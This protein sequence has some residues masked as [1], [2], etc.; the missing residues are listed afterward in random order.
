MNSPQSSFGARWI[1]LLGFA[2]A[3]I[4]A[5]GQTTPQKPGAVTAP[6]TSVPGATTPGVL[7]DANA[8]VV[9][10]TEAPAQTK[11]GAPFRVRVRM[12]RAAGDAS[13]REG[14]CIVSVQ[15]REFSSR[16]IG[17]VPWTED[18]DV[19]ANSVGAVEIKA[20]PFTDLDGQNR[21]AMG[22][23]VTRKLQVVAETPFARANQQASRDG[24][25]L[26]LPDAA[27]V[28]AGTSTPDGRVLFTVLGDALHGHGLARWD[29]KTGVETAYL[30]L[31]SFSGTLPYPGA[32]LTYERFNNRLF[33]ALGRTAENE[34][35]Q[36]VLLELDATTL[37]VRRVVRSG[38]LRVAM[39]QNQS[40]E[41]S[42]LPVGVVSGRD[43]NDVYVAASGIHPA[44]NNTWGSVAYFNL[45]ES[46]C[47]RW[48]FIAD[49]GRESGVGGLDGI[50][51]NLVRP[52]GG[53]PRGSGLL[54]RIYMLAGANTPIIVEVTGTGVR[55]FPSAGVR[56]LAGATVDRLYGVAES[57]IKSFDL[58]LAA[59]TA[60]RLAGLPSVQVAG[61]SHSMDVRSALL[62]GGRVLVAG[63]E[64]FAHW[65]I[66][67][68]TSSTLDA[69]MVSA[70]D[71][72][73]MVSEI[74]PSSTKEVI[75]RID[76]RREGQQWGQGA[77]VF[78]FQPLQ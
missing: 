67:T 3:V 18:I 66:A 23:A 20:T 60:T 42:G 41:A 65:T 73:K 44:N 45:R 28:Q 75:L 12:E 36:L 22:K 8:P 72:Y 38:A 59:P 37:A 1:V 68:N 71:P 57:A 30:P 15:G 29:T 70:V 55:S 17:Q 9:T 52:V 6:R 5:Q 54:S 50:T 49:L 53:P 56:H 10:I 46:R 62:H 7:L 74:L 25:R 76:T 24:A 47:V 19:E 61:G 63:T 58:G 77:P 13:Y 33:V 16:N 40:V 32:C 21:R 26:T 51:F 69:S 64:G 39:G 11:A 27:T 35:R 34:P 31:A 78:Y 2:A 43:G 4:A 14:G 48:G